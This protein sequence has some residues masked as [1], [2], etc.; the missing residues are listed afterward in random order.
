[1]KETLYVILFRQ[2]HNILLILE[3]NQQLYAISKFQQSETKIREKME[4]TLTLILF[5]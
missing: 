2:I 4:K 5:T 1:M 3:Y